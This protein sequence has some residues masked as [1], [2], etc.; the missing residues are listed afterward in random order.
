M[1]YK[2]NTNEE[3]KI[4]IWVTLF[5][6]IGGVLGTYIANKTGEDISENFSIYFFNFGYLFSSLYVFVLLVKKTGWVLFEFPVIEVVIA[7]IF[8]PFI[9]TFFGI[10]YFIKLIL[11]FVI[12]LLVVIPFF[13]WNVGKLVFSR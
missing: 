4:V 3:K 7:Y 8:L 13:L 2:T 6:I 1:S 10:W 5:F 9:F 12:S 11:L